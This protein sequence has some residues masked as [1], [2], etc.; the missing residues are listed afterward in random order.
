M[1]DV[2]EANRNELAH[3]RNLL[4]ARTDGEGKPKK[5]YTANVALLR[6]EIARLEKDNAQ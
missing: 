1:P 4:E 2:R 6:A 3:F 5:G